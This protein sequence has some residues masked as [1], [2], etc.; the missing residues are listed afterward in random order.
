MAIWW[1]SG[2]VRFWYGVA[3]DILNA[4][5]TSLATAIP[6]SSDKLPT[7]DG[8]YRT[9]QRRISLLA[10][11]FPSLVFYW[12]LC[13][14][15]FRAAWKAKRGQYDGPTW[16]ASSQDVLHALESV[17]VVFEMTGLDHLESVDGP[18]L[19]VGNHQGTLETMVLPGMIQPIRETT[20][21]V[22]HALIEYPIFK[23][24][25]ISRDPIA[26]SQTDPRGDFKLMMS[27]GKERL[28]K[29]VSLVVFPQGERSEGFDPK[30]FN[31]I[32]V[33]L[34]SR[35]KVPIVPVALK[36]DAWAMGPIISDFGKID[37]SKK[38]H[39][40][41]APPIRVEGRGADENQAIIEFISGKLAHWNAQE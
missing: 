8:A 20:F 16:A 25:M 2:E 15:V 9:P 36:T 31:S 30:Q 29:G 41:F 17:G 34:A 22:K 38:V 21:V 35:A 18:C 19:I 11:L 5:M 10:K 7:V 14:I 32:G 3:V 1:R 26:V 27:G 12:R 33:K 6:M 13:G 23:H 28:A 4:M 24:V 39:F 37:P 40:A